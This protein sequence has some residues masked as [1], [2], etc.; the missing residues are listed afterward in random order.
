[1][2]RHALG[3]LG[4]IAASVL[5]A[6]SAAMNYRFGFSLGKTPLDGEI[7]GAASAAADCFKA[8]VPFFFFAAWRNRMWSQAFAAVIV[9]AVVSGY[10]MTSA[11]GHAALNRLDTTGKRALAAAN[12]KDLRADEQRVK[13]QLAWVP[14]HRPAQTI[15]A[16][17]DGVKTQRAWQ[18]TNGCTEV[19]GRR[20]REY[21]Q[22]YHQLSAELASALQ[23]Q[24]LEGRIAEIGAKL[25][26]TAG[27]TVLSEADPQASVLAHLSGLQLE[28]VQMALAVFVA[29]LIE[30][31]SGFGMYVAFAYWRM[32]D[33]EAR[34]S[35]RVVAAEAAG[36]LWSE[37]PSLAADSAAGAAQT[38][39]AGQP[40][41]ST[42]LG[43][44]DNKGMPDARAMPSRAVVPDSDVQRFY[45]ERVVT[46]PD[47]SSV[48]STELY[49]EYCAWCEDND[50]VPFAHPRVTREISELGVKKE[51]IGRRT[52]YF[53][54]ALRS[55]SD[56]EVAETKAPEPA[57][58]AA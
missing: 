34:P 58:K 55:V 27:A 57:H 42:T 52:R 21:C 4:V 8:L 29:I 3:V 5:L 47:S 33:H 43:A 35:A 7:Y 18:L 54:I 23:S 17:I 26:K 24:K 48:T 39:R 32:H 53:G 40:P 19:V 15:E 45:R 6:V 37:Q 44:N 28:T 50:K 31:G 12:Y 56:Q 2:T 38:V 13:E 14:K 30:I 25:A 1:M 10:S 41:A 36:S 49:E 46:A 11:L 22:Q 16:E 20:N 51:R 9:W